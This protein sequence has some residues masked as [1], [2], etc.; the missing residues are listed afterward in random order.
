M[1]ACQMTVNEVIEVVN[2]LRGDRWLKDDQA[3]IDALSGLGFAEQPGTVTALPSGLQ[4][5]HLDPP[6]GIDHAT[7]SS[8]DGEPTSVIMFIASSLESASPTT[9]SE[10][11]ALVSSLTALL[12]SPRRVWADEPTPLLW[13]DADLDIG[14]QLFD[15][16]DSTV[17]VWVEHRERS[18]IAEQ[19]AMV[20]EDA[21]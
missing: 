16:H 20:E 21:R 8:L 13:P 15:R 6:P 17:M 2:S 11:E 10:Y 1:N 5:R 14:V 9:R 18:K 3:A 7:L 19:R 4:Q 12:G